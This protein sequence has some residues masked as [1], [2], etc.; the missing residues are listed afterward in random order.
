MGDTRLE[1]SH[2]NELTVTVK[3]LEISIR[4]KLIAIDLECKIYT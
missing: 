1:E 4:K 3:S 2:E